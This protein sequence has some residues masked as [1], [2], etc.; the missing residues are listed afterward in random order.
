MLGIFSPNIL[1]SDRY[2]FCYIFDL[3]LHYR[4]SVKTVSLLCCVLLQNRIIMLGKF[5]YY[6][7]YCYILGF[8]IVLDHELS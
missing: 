8:F 5:L 7:V 3:V 1:F 4:H 2:L 6:V